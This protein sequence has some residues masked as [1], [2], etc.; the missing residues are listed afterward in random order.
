MAVVWAAASSGVG[1]SV[2]LS[3]LYLP[4]FISSL[5]HFCNVFSILH[6]VSVYVP[7][8]LMYLSGSCWL[9]CRA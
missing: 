5:L 6:Y 7:R 3:N 9:V 4:V 2:L 8:F 1:P